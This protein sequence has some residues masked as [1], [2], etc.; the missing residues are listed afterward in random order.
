MVDCPNCHAPMQ[1]RDAA[2]NAA[3]AHTVPIGSC[4]AC[5]LFWFPD[6]AILR[7]TPQT[8]LDLFQLIGIAGAA[9]VSLQGGYTCPDCRH[10]LQ[11]THD[12]A[13]TMHF[14]YWRCPDDHGQLITFGQFLAEKNM[15]RP[16]SPDEL[17]KLRATV[18]QIN[19]SQCGAPIDLMH[20][21]ACPH[22]G[23]AVALIDPEGVAKAV[24]EL[25]TGA[26]AMTTQSQA[27]AQ[28]AISNAQLD[29]LFDLERMRVQENSTDLIAVGAAAIGALIGGLIA[30]R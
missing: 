16:P 22:C 19:C 26:T 8:V 28:T 20:D 4:G 5:N 13:R 23:A 2:V 7:L 1:S 15:I 10:T 24:R 6:G 27:T 25:T 21:S 29:A 9:D 17:E 3:V 12:L 11:Y 14:T 30:S 18:R